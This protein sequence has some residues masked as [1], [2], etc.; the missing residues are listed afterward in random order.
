MTPDTQADQIAE[1]GHKAGQTIW[2]SIEDAYDAGLPAKRMRVTFDVMIENLCEDLPR[3]VVK[4]FR[5]SAYEALPIAA[6]SLVERKE[7]DSNAS[8]AWDE[9][10]A[11]AR[12]DARL[13][14]ADH[15]YD[16]AR[17]NAA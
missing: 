2:A 5:A 3:E 12:D 15:G 9:F 1:C 7:I 11:E 6:V 17:E 10:V 16:M 4:L 14:A 8:N 13:Q